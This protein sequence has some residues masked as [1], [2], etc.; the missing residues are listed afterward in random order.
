MASTTYTSPTFDS[1]LKSL[2][3]TQRR[4]LLR[5]LTEHPELFPY[6]IKNLNQKVLSNPK[7]YGDVL[8]WEEQALK[9]L[10]TDI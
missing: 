6:V 2:N 10:A 5:L 3:H 4:E 8:T 7:K 9:L 1:L